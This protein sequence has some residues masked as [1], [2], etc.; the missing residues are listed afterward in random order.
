[1]W[2]AQRRH[3]TPVIDARVQIA[4][5]RFIQIRWR[6]QGNFRRQHEPSDRQSAKHIG[7]IRF[8]MMRHRGAGL[9]P[10]ILDDHLLN[11]PMPLM[12][13]RDALKAF[14]SPNLAD[15]NQDSR[16]HRHRRLAS[17]IE[18]AKALQRPLVGAGLMWHFLYYDRRL[19]FSSIKPASSRSPP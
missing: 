17:G 16:R 18:G 1:M 12:N 8:A 2:S 19:T 14:D 6:L 5:E 15:A 3:S 7:H 4:L 9:R 13:V 10:E 11:V